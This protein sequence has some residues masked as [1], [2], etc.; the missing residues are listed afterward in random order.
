MTPIETQ[1]LT[2]VLF[3]YGLVI[4]VFFAGVWVICKVYD[5]VDETPE[6]QSF[7]EAERIAK[8]ATNEFKKRKRMRSGF[9][10]VFN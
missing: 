9:W 1:A 8:Q 6:E 5:C 3:W 10:N 4:L 2:D 7:R